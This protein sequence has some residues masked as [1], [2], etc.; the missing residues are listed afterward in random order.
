MQF[1][2]SL[3]PGFDSNISEQM[4]DDLQMFLFGGTKTLLFMKRSVKKLVPS[5]GGGVVGICAL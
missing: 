1:P 4:F 2:P 3:R 5:W